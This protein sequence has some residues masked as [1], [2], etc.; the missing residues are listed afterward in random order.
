LGP[1][2]TTKKISKYADVENRLITTM[3]SD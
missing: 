1:T 2:T 3:N